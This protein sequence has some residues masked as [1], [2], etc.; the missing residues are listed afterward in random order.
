[1]EKQQD[2]MEHLEKLDK[3]SCKDWKL[4]HDGDKFIL[5]ACCGARQMWNNKKHP[6]TLYIDIRKE[7]KGFI[8]N[9]RNVEI[10]PD[11]QAD[12]SNLPDSIKS[13]RFKL[14]VWDTP[15]FKARKL[16]GEMLKKFGGLHPETW[17]SDLKKGFKEL[18]SV[19]DNYGVLLFKFSD[20]HIKFKEVLSLFPKEP[21]FFNRTSG[22]G[23][24]D[25]KWFCFMK[26]PENV[27][28]E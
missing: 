20:Y 1:M 6:N 21:L 11:I 14:I 16:T 13:Q 23:K 15:H 25:T 10:N 8:P 19:L 12:F 28:Q 2:F 9:Q 18:W 3:E 5:D 24:S 26:I 17:Q 27:E 7:E 22:S 4:A